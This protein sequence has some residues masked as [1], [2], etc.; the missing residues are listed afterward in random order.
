MAKIG[1]QDTVNVS[2]PSEDLEQTV[3]DLVRTTAEKVG[4]V[5]S[6]ISA[7]M[8]RLATV[9]NLD[10]VEAK[11]MAKIGE[12]DTVN[13]SKPSEDLEQTV[14]ELVRKSATMADLA[15]VEKVDQV[16]AKLM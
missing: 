9:E 16:E 1:E 13:V 8:A 2:K 11:L 5:E 15:T 10:Q 7:T 4:D 6:R 12:Q 3:A 14:T